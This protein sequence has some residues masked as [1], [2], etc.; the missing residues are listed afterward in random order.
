MTRLLVAFAV[1]SVSGC[2]CAKECT[3]GGD[4]MRPKRILWPAGPV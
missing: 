1:L 3:Q 4:G 2:L